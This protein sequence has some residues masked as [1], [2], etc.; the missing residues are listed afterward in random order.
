M[1]LIWASYFSDA[2]GDAKAKWSDQDKCAF[3]VWMDLDLGFNSNRV[4]YR[5]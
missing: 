4:E 1:L 2:C 3:A 5:D